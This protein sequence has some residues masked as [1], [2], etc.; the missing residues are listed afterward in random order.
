MQQP[1]ESAPSPDEIAAWIRAYLCKKL[2]RRAQDIQG[3]TKFTRLGMDS[4][5]AVELTADLE[6]FIGRRIEPTIVFR[7][8]T[9]DAL[10]EYCCLLTPQGAPQQSEGSA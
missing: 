6:E 3:D 7:H 1:S 10:A 9:I 4:V 2:N 5:L 8:R